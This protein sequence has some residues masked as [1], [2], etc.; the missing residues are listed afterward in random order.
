MPKR[1]PKLL[2]E[3]ILESVEKIE[4]YTHGLSFEDF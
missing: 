3:D 4:R 1:D 2:F